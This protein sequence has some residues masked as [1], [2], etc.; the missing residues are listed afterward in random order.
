[1]KRLDITYFED[2]QVLTDLLGWTHEELWKFINLDDWD[3]G[4]AFKGKHLKDINFNMEKMLQGPCDNE[5]KEV[6]DISGKWWTI[7]MA[8]HS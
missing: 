6:K 3:Y 7:G 2:D 5:W 8:Y 1:M 4:L